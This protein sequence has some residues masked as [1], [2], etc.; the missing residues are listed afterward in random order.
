[1]SEQTEITA[2]QVRT[3][4]RVANRLDEAGVD[5]AELA[6]KIREF[7]ASAADSL[8]QGAGLLLALWAFVSWNLLSGSEQIAIAHFAEWRSGY[9]AT[10]VFGFVASVALYLG[11]VGNLLKVGSSRWF[12]M[13]SL[14]F[15][16]FVNFALPMGLAVD[17]FLWNAFGWSLAAQV[18]LLRGA[19]A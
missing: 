19:G 7:N 17:A 1:M 15:L 3:A 13:D 12:G 18:V 10:A 11:V 5:L 6:P 8:R 16:L 9:T 14:S 2:E 4:V